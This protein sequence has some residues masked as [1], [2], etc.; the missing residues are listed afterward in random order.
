[1]ASPPLP[2]VDKN[3]V[4]NVLDVAALA[5]FGG[6][7]RHTVREHLRRLGIGTKVGGRLVVMGVELQK[8][9]P[10]MYGALAHRTA[11]A[12]ASVPPASPASG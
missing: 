5:D 1:M 10:P 7:T 8:R 12:R 11:R 6:F 2:A 9:W 4:P 3:G